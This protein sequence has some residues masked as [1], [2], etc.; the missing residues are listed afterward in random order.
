VCWRLNI[1]PVEI[2]AGHCVAFS[3]PKELAD[4]LVMSVDG[5]VGERFRIG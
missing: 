1:I 3:H 5:L 2:A 4:L